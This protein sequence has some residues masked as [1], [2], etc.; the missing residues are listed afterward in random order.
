MQKYKQF[1]CVW[2][3]ENLPSCMSHFPSGFIGIVHGTHSQLYGGKNV[4]D[5]SVYQ[6]KGGK[7]VNTFSWYPESTLRNI[8]YAPKSSV[9]RMIKNYLFD[10]EYKL[11]TN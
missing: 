3:S 5:Y 7:I 2:V 8:P 4:N 9:K 10:R 6:V 11:L 1:S